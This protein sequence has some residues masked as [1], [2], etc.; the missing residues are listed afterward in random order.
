MREEAGLSVKSAIDKDS[1][2]AVHSPVDGHYFS[3]RK[4]I[5]AQNEQS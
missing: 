5:S 4:L 2:A 1:F 3:K